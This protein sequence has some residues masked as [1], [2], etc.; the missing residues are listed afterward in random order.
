[1][2]NELSGKNAHQGHVVLYSNRL[3]ALKLAD[4]VLYRGW[5]EDP[6]ASQLLRLKQFADILQPGRF[7]Q[8]AGSLGRTVRLLTPRPDGFRNQAFCATFE[9]VL[10]VQDFHF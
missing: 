3:T 1:M 5:I 4:Q 8:K 10:L 2:D 7:R 6:A 9:N